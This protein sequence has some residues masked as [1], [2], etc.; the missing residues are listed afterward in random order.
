MAMDGCAL[1]LSSLRKNL[2]GSAFH[3]GRGGDSMKLEECK[4][5]PHHVMHVIDEVLCQYWTNGEY[6]AT[7]YSHRDNTVYVIGCPI[8][9]ELTAKP[10]AYRISS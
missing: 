1:F 8:E 6:R 10:V 2:R 3:D 4:K 9:E 7:G 5:C